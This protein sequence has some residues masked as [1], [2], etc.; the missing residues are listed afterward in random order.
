MFL[1]VNAVPLML[2]GLL[3]CTSVFLEFRKALTISATV[4][5]LHGFIYWLVFCLSELKTG[6]LKEWVE[7]LFFSSLIGLCGGVI[8]TAIGSAIYKIRGIRKVV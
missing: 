5:F 3:G 4:G 8:Y 6:R 1:L 7:I 2:L